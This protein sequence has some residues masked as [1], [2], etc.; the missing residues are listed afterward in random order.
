MFLCTY[1]MLIC[2]NIVH[3]FIQC[4][5]TT[6]IPRTGGDEDVQE[7]APMDGPGTITIHVAL[8]IGPVPPIPH[9]E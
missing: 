5:F 8:I 3:D 6:V 1:V 9:K 7:A 4:L 2:T